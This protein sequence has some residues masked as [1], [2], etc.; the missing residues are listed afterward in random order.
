MFPAEALSDDGFLGGR[1][2]L[3]QPQDGYRAGVDPVL[4]AAS[5][6]AQAGETVLDLGL[7]AGA[8]SLCLAARVPGLALAGIELQM[9]YAALAR[10]N[11]AANGIA[12][13]VIE[14]DVTAMPAALKARAF[15]HVIANPP[16]Y[17]PTRRTPAREAGREAALGESLPLADWIAA[18][19]KRLA[20]KGAM[21]LI[22]PPERLP[23]A[24]AALARGLGSIE[25]KP[26]MPR[27]GRPAGLI[28]LRA[29]KGGRAAFRLHA[30]L[31][32]HE[33][34]SH[35]GDRES[36]RSEV[37]AILREGAALKF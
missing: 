8:A 26:I 5:V 17:E 18:G 36:Y 20:P 31:I 24:L 25:A 14:G 32:L 19:A 12:L 27:E 29:R 6:P 16:Y 15:D 1:L 22:L 13:E 7:G 33:G 35:E 28:L 3:K 11:A 30:P 4:L 2:R 9:E 37:Q 34:A 21:S 23:E 10:A